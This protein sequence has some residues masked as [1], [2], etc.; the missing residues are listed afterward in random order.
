MT[1]DTEALAAIL[2]EHGTDK[3]P[4]SPG[5]WVFKVRGESPVLVQK[6]DGL[7]RY[8]NGRHFRLQDWRPGAHRCARLDLGRMVEAEVRIADLEA[9]VE[10][11][12]GAL[13]LMEQARNS[14]QSRVHE[15]ESLLLEELEQTEAE[16]GG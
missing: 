14:A 16:G 3:R 4:D 9:D 15:L 6:R 2:E 13:S 8:F 1:Q 10:A 11:A 7:L 5:L 12:L